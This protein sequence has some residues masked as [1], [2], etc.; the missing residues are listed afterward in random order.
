MLRLPIAPL[1]TC[2]FFV[3]LQLTAES[4]VPG[5]GKVFAVLFAA[6]RRM[7]SKPQ[8]PRN[9]AG[10]PARMSEN[11]FP[12]RNDSQPT[13]AGELHFFP[14]PEPFSVR[15]CL[16]EQM[17]RQDRCHQFPSPPLPRNLPHRFQIGAARASRPARPR[18]FLWRGGPQLRLT[19]RGMVR[20]YESTVPTPSTG[21]EGGSFSATESPLPDVEPVRQ[22]GFLKH[23]PFI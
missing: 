20:H 22:G 9:R 18:S 6:G 23:V 5:R 4:Y 17:Q 12:A 8:T 2:D 11:L 3:T 15:G 1:A 13:G 16:Y 7:R 14:A 19:K 10:C 21:Q